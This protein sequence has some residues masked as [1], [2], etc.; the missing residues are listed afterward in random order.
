MLLKDLVSNSPV[1][2]GNTKFIG[3]DGHG[4]SG[5]STLAELLAKQFS[6]EIIHQYLRQ[7]SWQLENENRAFGTKL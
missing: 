6:A 2:A 7:K 1:K 4:G 3:I 5:K